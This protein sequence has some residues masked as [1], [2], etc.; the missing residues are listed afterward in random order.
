MSIPEK[1]LLHGEVVIHETK[2]HWVGLIKEILYSVGW[3]VA[4]I[5]F[6]P[7]LDNFSGGWVMWPLTAIWAWFAIGGLLG[8]LST[9]VALTNQRIIFR[10]GV[11]SKQGYE[12]PVD[13]IQDVGFQQSLIQRMFG[14]GDLVVKTSASS[15]RTA[16]RNIPDPVTMKTMIGEAR[17]S[18]IEGRF[19][20]AGGALAAASGHDRSSLSAAEQLEILGRLHDEGK[21]SSDEF[22][23]EKRRLLG[24]G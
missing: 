23:A 14:A 9:T 8:W 1:I 13:Q 19:E 24:G 6:V 16:I 10:R 5:I 22:E 15:G 12:I 4:F 17:E 21:L 2:L 3:L 7:M 20:R 18:K 11:V